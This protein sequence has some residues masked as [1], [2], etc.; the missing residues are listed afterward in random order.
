MKFIRATHTHTHTYLTRTLTLYCSR[1]LAYT[2]ST[3]SEN[4][5]TLVELCYSC[6]EQQLII[7]SHSI[8]YKFTLLLE[9]QLKWHLEIMNY[10]LGYALNSR[11]TKSLF[12]W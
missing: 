7:A 1:S 11:A 8:C 3:Q 5:L 2:Y 12:R 9:H 6:A 10:E 4:H